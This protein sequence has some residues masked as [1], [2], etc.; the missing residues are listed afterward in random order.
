M[1]DISREGLGR[2]AAL[3][4]AVFMLRVPM[5]EPDGSHLGRRPD[6]GKNFLSKPT[7]PRQPPCWL[8]QVPLTGLLQACRCPLCAFLVLS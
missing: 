7:A 4:R 1:P 3:G 2:Y 5:A 8:G 6:S